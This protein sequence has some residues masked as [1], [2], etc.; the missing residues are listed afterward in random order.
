MKE[1]PDNVI[2]NY[3]T[4]EYDAYKRSYPTSFNSKNFNLDKIEKFESETQH[5]FKSKLFEIKKDYDLLIKEVEWT[6]TIHNSKYPFTPIVGKIY[7]LYKGKEC[8]FLSIIS[9]KEWNAI[10]LGKYK[11]NSNNTWTKL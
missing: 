6:E 9:P 7:Y 2:Y 11:L 8:N 10:P 5:Y 4:K 3:K 1:K